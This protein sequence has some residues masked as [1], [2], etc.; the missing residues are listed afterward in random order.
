MARNQLRFEITVAVV[1][2]AIEN[3]SYLMLY[4][5]WRATHERHDTS[6]PAC[7]SE[8]TVAAGIAQPCI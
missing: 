6:K 4:T 3:R 7:D 5:R 2:Y 8:A 1:K